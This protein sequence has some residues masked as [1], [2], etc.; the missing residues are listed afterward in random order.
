MDAIVYTS[1]SGFTKHYAELLAA[2]TGLAVYS[3]DE[4]GNPWR[5]APPSFIWAG[6]WPAA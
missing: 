5:G 3:L 1:N 2:E 4:A 6:S